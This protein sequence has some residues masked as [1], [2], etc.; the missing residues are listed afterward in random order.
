MWEAIIA[1]GVALITSLVS[2]G[3]EAEAQRV[4]EEMAAQYGPDI[5]PELD[6]A[7]AQEAQSAFQGVSEDDAIRRE[8]L[9][10]MDELGEI[11]STGGM[12]EGDKAQRDLAR[13]SVSARAKSRSQSLA[14]ELGQRGGQSSGLAAILASQ[15]QQD[16]MEALAGLESEIAAAGSNRAFEAL[17]AKGGMASGMRGDDW[18]AL[19]GKAEAL[20][21]Q[22]RFNA[23]QRQQTEL[24]NRGLPQQQ[25]DNEMRRLN[26]RA[27]AMQGVAGGLEQ[28]GANIRQTG[29]GVG[30]SI[31]SYGQGWDDE[32]EDK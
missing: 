27:A 32:D 5:L 30:N 23:S 13:R 8:Q 16:E 29:A 28:Q 14:Q 19:S 10:V 31:I 15:A 11:Y 6:A 9:G 25:F 1:A 2:A 12:T 18:R 17:R 7:V 3:K 24:Y 4:R 26:A 20:D 21:L 22:N